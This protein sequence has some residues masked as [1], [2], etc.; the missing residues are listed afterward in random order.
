MGWELE[1]AVGNQMPNMALDQQK[2]AELLDAV[3][4]PSGGTSLDNIPPIEDGVISRELSEAI[5]N[6]QSVQNIAVDSIVQVGGETWKRLIDISEMQNIPPGPATIVL[7]V[8]E[9][10][11]AE[12]PQ[13]APTASGFPALQ[14][15]IKFTS[16]PFRMPGC[17]VEMTIS[18]PIKVQWG[19][20][21][22]VAI[23][24]SQDLQALDEAVKSGS[25]RDLGAAALDTLSYRLK[26]ESSTAVASLFTKISVTIALDGSLAIGG[27]IGD[28][29]TFYSLSF[30]PDDRSM[31]F[32]GSTKV[33]KRVDALGGEVRL[34]GALQITAKFTPDQGGDD[35][36][37]ALA[38]LIVLAGAGALLVSVMS[39]AAIVD[40]LTKVGIGVR[41]IVL[42]IPAFAP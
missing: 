2:V 15:S 24:L 38:S 35:E 22:P 41:E 39:E 21:Y 8:A 20:G 7:S 9:Q 33:D 27:S 31:I 23:E 11:I 4:L 19:E 12:I 42:R 40:Q 1:R 13:S 16:L 29:T 28:G 3:R 37:S 32:S 5:G 30:D 25:A 6:F 14:Y 18:G 36:A 26:V 17:R 34:T 10:S